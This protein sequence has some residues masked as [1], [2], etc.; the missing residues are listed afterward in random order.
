MSS[1]QE[2]STRFTM[3]MPLDEHRHLKML[4][5]KLGVTMTQLVML[6][7]HKTLEEYEEMMD[8]K[9]A[10]AILDRIDSGQEKMVTWDEMKKQL[11][12]DRS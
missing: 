8:A 7:L 1:Q 4:C 2:N 10:D 6:S 12:W 9:E 3:N 5:A 11:G